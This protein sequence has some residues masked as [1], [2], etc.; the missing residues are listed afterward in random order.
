MEDRLKELRQ[1]MNN[2]TFEQINFSN[3][4]RNQVHE[5]IKKQNEREDITLIAVLQLLL[6]KRTGYDL[7]QLL[8]ARGIESYEDK[9][10]C[11]YTFLHNLE[12][13]GFLTSKWDGTDVKY[14]Q[15]SKKGRKVLQHAEKNGTQKGFILKHLFEG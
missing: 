12:K 5:K 9:E 6:N 13:N 14:Y 2:T 3:R 11:L 7:T 8:R 4:L 10:G 1:K 15:T